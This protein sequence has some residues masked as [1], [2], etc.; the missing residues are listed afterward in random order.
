[1]EQ[2]IYDGFLLNCTKT[3]LI[4][5]FA[6]KVLSGT[7]RFENYNQHYCSQEKENKILCITLD[8]SKSDK[9]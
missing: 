5:Y 7:S 1:M 3:P 4:S 6:L 8:N 9:G 2:N